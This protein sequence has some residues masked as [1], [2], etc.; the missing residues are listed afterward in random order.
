MPLNQVYRKD[1]PFIVSFD[2]I[3]FVTKQGYIIFYLTKAYDDSAN[4][5]TLIVS[6][7]VDS[8]SRSTNVILPKNQT[9]AKLLDLDF[10]ILVNKAFTV[11]G[12]FLAEITRKTIA[13]GTSFLGSTYCILKLRKWD[14]LSETE[15]VSGKTST[16]VVSDD[17]IRY[18]RDAIHGLIST[19][20]GFKKGE[21]LRVTIE[22]WGESL[23]FDTN[24]TITFYHDPKSNE[25]VDTDKST[26]LTIHIPFELNI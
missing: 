26:D 1:P 3:N 10:D 14:G 12:E 20:Q 15:I 25:T 7:V 24:G 23:N 13:V 5:D 19:G 21:Y 16:M 11:K 22:I 9:L 17:G 18:T 4:E 8:S 6:D 2:S